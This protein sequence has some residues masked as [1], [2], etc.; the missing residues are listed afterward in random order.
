MPSQ[1][2]SAF[3][4]RVVTLRNGVEGLRATL[5]LTRTETKTGADGKKVH[6]FRASDATLDRY[7][8]VIQPK[9]WDVDEYKRN[10][11]IVDSHRYDSIQWLLGG[12]VD[13]KVTDEALIIGITFSEV[14]PLGQLAEGLVEEGWLRSGSVGFIPL[15]YKNGGAG[16]PSRTYTRQSLL[17]FSLTTIPANSN[18]LKLAMD[19]GHVSEETIKAVRK[20]LEPFC[21]KDATTPEPS[22]SGVVG[23]LARLLNLGKSL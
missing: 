1:L 7:D 22:A 10:P 8:E 15:D 13:V 14:N 23:D 12:G 9:G 21:S 4:E 20:S 11:V 2:K 17:E 5:G 18:A 3:G 16:Q 6:Y 19:H